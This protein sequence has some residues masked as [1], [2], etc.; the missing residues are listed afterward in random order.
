MKLILRTFALGSLIGTAIAL[1]ASSP[2]PAIVNY[3]ACTDHPSGAPCFDEPSNGDPPTL[4]H[5]WARVRAD[6]G[7]VPANTICAYA[8][9]AAGNTK[10]GS[11]CA[12]SAFHHTSVLSSPTPES[13]GQV[14]YLHD[15]AVLLNGVECSQIEV[16]FCPINSAVAAS[17]VPS[18]GVSEVASTSAEVTGSTASEMRQIASSH[19]QAGSEFRVVRHDPTFGS[20]KLV[21][22]VGNDVVCLGTAQY[23]GE[24]SPG[25]TSCTDA[26]VVADPSKAFYSVTYLGNRIYAVAGLMLDGIDTVTIQHA[27][28]QHRAVPVK[29]NAYYV[30]TLGAPRA[31]SW[32]DPQ[33]V[34]RSQLLEAPPATR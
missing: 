8:I 11:G 7:F 6:V 24:G 3:W 15:L 26:A 18:S 20:N 1:A 10:A 17:A 30:E 22:G 12:G 13:R 28:G 25:G 19:D 33:G 34:P 32:T 2:A 31:V 21:V 14:H 23:P 9:T 29:D 27:D 5:Q 4:Y 16:S